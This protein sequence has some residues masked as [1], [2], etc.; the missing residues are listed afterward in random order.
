MS[1]KTSKGED[2]NDL[3]AFEAQVSNS[4]EVGTGSRHASYFIVINEGAVKDRPFQQFFDELPDYIRNNFNV[5]F[6]AWNME[7]NKA[8]KL[9]IHLYLELAD[10]GVRFKTMLTK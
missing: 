8:G 9:H 2:A 4:G 10:N 7:K 3:R 5:E 6:F 1:K